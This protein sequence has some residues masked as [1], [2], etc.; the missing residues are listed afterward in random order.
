M[1]VFAYTAQ[2]P[3]AMTP[4]GK[5]LVDFTSNELAAV[6]SAYSLSDVNSI[7]DVGGGSGNLLAALLQANPSLHGTVI[8]HRT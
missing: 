4:F 7:M 8:S 6:A 3:E 1:S 5:M 2:S